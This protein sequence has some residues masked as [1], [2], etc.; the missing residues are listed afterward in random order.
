MK[1]VKIT[2]LKTTLDKELALEYGVEGL[3]TCPML[4]EKQV[5]YA[6]YA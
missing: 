1:K 4:K 5:F 6:D 2:V 3:S